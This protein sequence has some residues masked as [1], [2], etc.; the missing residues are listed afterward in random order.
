MCLLFDKYY[1][2]H[3]NNGKCKDEVDLYQLY[4]RKLSR[5]AKAFISQRDGKI[6][7]KYWANEEDEAFWGGFSTSDKLLLF[8]AL[9]TRMSIDVIVIQYLL[10][11]GM[12]EIRHLNHYFGQVTIADLQLDQILASGTAE[13]H[14]HLGTAV[15]FFILWE[16]IMQNPRSI[17]KEA[18]H[19]FIEHLQE[20]AHTPAIHFY[21]LV[22]GVLRVT[23][24]LYLRE[25]EEHPSLNESFFSYWKKMNS[26][27]QDRSQNQEDDLLY[28]ILVGTLYGDLLEEIEDETEQ[29]ISDI[30]SCRGIFIK[31]WDELVS[32]IDHYEPNVNIL[33]NIFSNT[34]NIHTSE[35]NI[36]LF[37]TMRYLQGEGEKDEQFIKIFFQYLRI[38]NEIFGLWVQDNNIRGLKYFNDFYHRNGD[39][40]ALCKK[41]LWERII[42]AQFQDDT[43]KKIEFRTTLSNKESDCKKWIIEF[44]KAYEKV[45]HQKYCRYDEDK[46]QYIP[47]KSF[48]Q[49]GIVYHLIK[50]SDEEMPEKCWKEYYSNKS[51]DV[52]RQ[53]YKQIQQQYFKQINHLKKLRKDYPILSRYLVGLDAASEENNTPVWVFAPVYEKARDS[54]EEPLYVEEYSGRDI[55][56]QS[57]RFTFHAGEDFRHILSGLRRI[58]E[59]IE[60]CKFHAGDRIGHGVALGIEPQEWAQNCPMVIL[61]RIEILN[62]L[63]WVW[64]LFSKY[65]NKMQSVQFY[66]EQEIFKHAKAIYKNMQGITVSILIEAYR[67]QFKVFDDVYNDCYE[68]RRDG[69]QETGYKNRVFCEWASEEERLFWTVDKLLAANHCKKYLVDMLEPIYYKVTPQEIEIAQEAQKILRGKVSQAGIIV[70]VNPSSNAYITEVESLF[71]NQAFALNDEEKLQENVMICINTDNPSSCQTNISNELAYIYYGLLAQGKSKEVALRWINKLRQNGIYAS[72]IENGITKEQLLKEL[73]QLVKDLQ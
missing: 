68:Y 11:N 14:L 61:P 40:V 18:F 69:E 26:S 10:D 66:L 25:K 6:V 8:Q 51:F 46:Q 56:T 54:L 17:E 9:N 58:D 22:E 16:S 27:M 36:F 33:S 67:K 64:W 62:N 12:T 7:Y 65:P 55:Y 30:D 47:Y 57:L 15:N 34:A 13:N 29:K 59:V 4:F 50:R 23:I 28:N 5:M 3:I 60:H 73:E 20:D 52:R 49:A 41:N 70:E 71:R 63:L 45:V 37:K 19:K 72:F 38:K 44:L 2:R 35:E 24:G 42:S 21:I 32:Y 1:V 39:V 53:S 43:L 48:P 31:I